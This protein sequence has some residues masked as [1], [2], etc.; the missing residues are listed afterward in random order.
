MAIP[1]WERTDMGMK[2]AENVA[3]LASEGSEGP[4]PHPR[5]PGSPRPR[6]ARRGRVAGVSR[7]RVR[8]DGCGV[9]NP[10]RL[11]FV[12]DL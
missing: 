11:M 8:P 3:P 10:G 4:A 1:R 9:E 7:A 6:P 2:A 12:P 5:H